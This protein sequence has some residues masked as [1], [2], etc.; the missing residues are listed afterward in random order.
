MGKTHKLLPA[1]TQINPTAK[2]E[3]VDIP[4]SMSLGHQ[5]D[6]DE[7]VQQTRERK[8]RGGLKKKKKKLKRK[9][10]TTLDFQ[11]ANKKEK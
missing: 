6:Q 9:K 1:V 5:K 4:V 10:T 2:R 7:Q 11:L 3:P 8:T